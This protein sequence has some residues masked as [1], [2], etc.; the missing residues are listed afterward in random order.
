MRMAAVT[1]KARM[2][3]WITRCRAAGFDPRIVD[4]EAS[5]D[6]VTATHRLVTSAG[7]RLGSGAVFAGWVIR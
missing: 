6:V 4:W 3:G 1:A 5:C 2:H 7:G